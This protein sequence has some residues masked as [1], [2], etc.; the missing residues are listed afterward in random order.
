ME[1]TRAYQSE[2]EMPLFPPGQVTPLTA[3]V[4]AIHGTPTANPGPLRELVLPVAQA[5]RGG[6]YGQ[7]VLFVSSAMDGHR[8]LLRRRSGTDPTATRPQR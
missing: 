1:L 3:T 6:V 4:I 8:P 7:T 2:G 5:I